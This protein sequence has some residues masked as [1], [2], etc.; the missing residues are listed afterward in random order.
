MEAEAAV[1]AALPNMV[2]RDPLFYR[3]EE[4]IWSEGKLLLHLQPLHSSK[5]VCLL[6]QGV[7]WS[8]I[9]SVS[10]HMLSG[11]LQIVASPASCPVEVWLSNCLSVY[12]I[13]VSSLSTCVI[14]EAEAFACC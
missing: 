5:W 9:E 10:W 1:P 6:C 7:T 13:W 14:H 12:L 4:G 11:P 8:S 3:G 2:T